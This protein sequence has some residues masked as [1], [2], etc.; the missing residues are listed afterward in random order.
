MRLLPLTECS[1]CHG[2][3]SRWGTHCVRKQCLPSHRFHQHRLHQ[4]IY[5][6]ESTDDQG[7][8]VNYSQGLILCW[9]LN[10]RLWPYRHRRR[11]TGTARSCGRRGLCPS[12][13]PYRA[14]R[15]HRSRGRQPTPFRW[16]YD[17]KQYE[18][19]QTSQKDNVALK[20]CSRRSIYVV[21]LLMN[22]D[23]H[24]DRT[25]ITRLHGRRLSFLSLVGK[26]EQGTTHVGQVLS[27][28]SAAC[29]A[30]SLLGRL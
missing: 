19:A 15:W 12:T 26:V 21:P 11:S 10:L 3:C 2:R 4:I 9:A 29:H 13:P 24:R 8:V 23:I 18:E 16:K 14:H 22:Q 20:K 1:R 7:K 30:G 6:M 27:E 28:Q 17:R 5:V 25:R